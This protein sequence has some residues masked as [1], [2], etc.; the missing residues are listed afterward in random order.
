MG[1]T[2]GGVQFPRSSLRTLLT[3]P[4]GILG[5]GATFS[6]ELRGAEQPFI[7]LLIFDSFSTIAVHL[8]TLMQ[9]LLVGG[10]RS[11]QRAKT[12]LK[13]DPQLLLHAI[14]PPNLPGSCEGSLAYPHRSGCPRHHLRCI[15]LQF[16]RR[17]RRLQNRLF[18]YLDNAGGPIASAVEIVQNADTYVTV[19][20]TMPKASSYRLGIVRAYAQALR[21]VF[22]VLTGISTV[23]GLVSLAIRHHD[24]DRGLDSEHVFRRGSDWLN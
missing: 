8:G 10:I 19:L 5:I 16:R 1:L 22:G 18:R 23:G 11:F 21:V 13:Q 15:S 2:W 17:H 20:Q 24:M 4:K 7:R 14:L 12:V 9:G 3:L 6:W